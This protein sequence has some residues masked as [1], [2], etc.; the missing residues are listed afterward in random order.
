MRGFTIAWVRDAHRMVRRKRL[1]TAA[2]Q[3]GAK[4]QVERGQPSLVD[5]AD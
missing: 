3:R 1:R 2:T 5:S 4:A